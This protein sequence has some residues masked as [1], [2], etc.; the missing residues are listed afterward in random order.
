VRESEDA[1]HVVNESRQQESLLHFAAQGYTFGM[2]TAVSIPDEVFDEAERLARSL[3]K[4]RSE[5]YS[6]A[7]AEYIARHGGDRVTELMDKAVDEIGEQRDDFVTR[8]SL[9][10]L[11][12]SEW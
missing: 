5:V 2:K 1:D 12:Q 4:S 8:A 3:K 9:L 7:L 10:R 11:E 6:R